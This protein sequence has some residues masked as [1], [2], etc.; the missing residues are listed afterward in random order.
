MLLSPNIF[1]WYGVW[2]VP[3]LAVA[4]SAPWIAFT[5]S[6]MF[7]YAFFLQQPWAMPPWARVVEFAPLAVGAALLAGQTVPRAPVGGPR[8]MTI[9]AA[10]SRPPLPRSLYIE[11]TSRCNSLCETCILTFGGR[12]PQKDLRWGQFRTIVDQFPVLERV[13]LHG[14]GEPLLNR[15]LPRMISHLKTRGATVLFNSNAITL[16]PKMGRALVDAGL[17]ELRVSLDASSRDTYAR[18]RGV[19]AFDKVV[20]NLERLAAVK[21]ELAAPRPASVALAHGLE[22]QHR[23]DPGSRAAGRPHGRLL[24]PSPAAGVQ[25]PRDRDRGPVAVRQTRGA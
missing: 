5:G 17:D 1:P 25:R 15:E 24:D 10:D 6:V 8:R 9:P 3:F 22:G 21:G 23:R 19:D 11:T 2:L 7:A 18:I 4:P 20:E 12:E 16:S 13:L 14:I